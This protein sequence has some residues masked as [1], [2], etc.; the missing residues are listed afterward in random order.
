M[1]HAGRDSIN[2][3]YKGPTGAHTTLSATNEMNADIHDYHVNINLHHGTGTPLS[4]LS[5]AGVGGVNI[6][7][8]ISTLY[9]LPVSISKT[10]G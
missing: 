7:C 9:P 5:L 6:T 10:T 1:A 4:P 2:Q 8:M 3:D